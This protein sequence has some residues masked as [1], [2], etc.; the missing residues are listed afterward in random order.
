MSVLVTGCCFASATSAFMAK[1]MDQMEAAETLH[2][3]ALGEEGHEEQLMVK[4][5]F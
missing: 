1:D 3:K 2:E 4:G 5:G